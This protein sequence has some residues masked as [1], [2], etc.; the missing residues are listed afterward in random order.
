MH[1]PIG[2]TPAT[3]YVL[4]PDLLDWQ[5]LPAAIRYRLQTLRDVAADRHTLVLRCIDDTQ[6]SRQE[7]QQA[8]RRLRELEHRHH[9]LPDDH[10]SLV[11]L[12]EVI[13]RAG[14]TIV[15]LDARMAE[16]SPAWAEAARLVGNLEKFLREHARSE[17]RMY[18]G[19]PPQLLKNE[20]AL[21]GLERASRR[22][23][24]LL[25]DRQ[26]ILAAPFPS[27]VA[28]EIARVQ[29]AKRAESAAP[30]VSGLVNC[31]DPIRFRIN[32]VPIETVGV[33]DLF[34]VDNVGLLAWVFEKEFLT[35]I[36][37]AIDIEADD[38]IALTTEQRLAKLKTI[39]GDILAAEREEAAFSDLAG[40]L[41][42]ADIDPRAFLNLDDTMP[43]QDRNI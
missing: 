22:G 21:T 12:N 23:R 39:D 4:P 25:A 27:A 37:R 18:A 14:A 33:D 16:L 5:Q 3:N 36:D 17:L 19:A 34:R 43:A 9:D 1:A 41:P 10:H 15:R 42:R 29:L 11:Q 7:M 20:T 8:Q 31:L 24:A 40:L 35:A 26:E 2:R 6:A 38:K 13:S 28:K 32:G 30:D